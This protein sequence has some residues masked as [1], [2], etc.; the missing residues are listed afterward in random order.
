[1]SFRD[2]M[3]D[4][5][6]HLVPGV[7]DG[8]ASPEAAGHGLAR[9][10][11]QGVHT[12]VVTPH[13]SGALTL[14]PDGLA[15]RMAE[16]DA[17][18]AQLQDVAQAEPEMRVLRGA[19]VMMDAPKIDLSDPRLRLAGTRFALVEFPFMT[20]PP[21]AELAIFHLRMAGWAPVLAHPE[22]YANAAPDLGDAEGWRRAGALLQVN[23]GS[24]LGRY[25]EEARDL[26]WGLLER[27]MA[28]FLSSDYH[29]RHRLSTADCR[30]E[31]ERRGAGEQAV[32][33]METNP[34]RLLAGD[35]PLPV[36][37]VRPKPSLWG[38][39]MG[40]G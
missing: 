2:G 26:A 19:E 24:L 22:R 17:G 27:G 25:G 34:A 29:T 11:A 33:L 15:R 14:N 32:L 38:R 3:I 1:M 6:N 4:F 13:V 30:A 8:A 31:L 7:D 20:V 35:D 18:W 12:V 21:H 39:L 5:H 23:A 37:P 16:L 9:F 40:R 10:R 28:E 36:P